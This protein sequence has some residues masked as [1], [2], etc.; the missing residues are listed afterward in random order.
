MQKP[1]GAKDKVKAGSSNQQN[2]ELEGTKKKREKRPKKK[3][4]GGGGG[5][6]GEK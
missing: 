4:M 3:K 2:L 6:E 5:G 1:K